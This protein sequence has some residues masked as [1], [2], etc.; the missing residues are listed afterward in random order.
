[1][2]IS[3]FLFGLHQTKTTQQNAK[4]TVE[5]LDKPGGIF[6]RNVIECF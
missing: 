1:M 6:Y 3:G 5:A 2:S 4:K